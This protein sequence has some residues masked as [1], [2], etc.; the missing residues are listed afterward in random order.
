MPM[1]G[2]RAARYWEFVSVISPRRISVPTEM[3]SARMGKRIKEP[4]ARSQGARGRRAIGWNTAAI[5]VTGLGGVPVSAK[6]VV[7]SATVTEGTGA[8]YVTVWPSD[9]PR[10]TASSLNFI[11]GQTVANLVLVKVPP[12]GFVNVYN[13]A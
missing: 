1:A 10:P 4:G 11:P 13:A 6:G 12:S 7:L 8:G 5:S 2:R 3:I 9:A